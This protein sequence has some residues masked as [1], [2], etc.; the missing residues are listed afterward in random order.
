MKKISAIG[1]R[2]LL[3][4]VSGVVG[5]AA[6]ATTTG[7]LEAAEGSRSSE[8]EDPK[9]KAQYRESEEVKAFYRVNRY[10]S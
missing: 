4:M 2:D 6:V 9:T 10:P 7:A 3:G 8:R 1:R 5:A